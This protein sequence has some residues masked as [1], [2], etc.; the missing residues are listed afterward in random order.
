LRAIV[1]WSR[2][3]AFRHQCAADAAEVD[4]VVL[5][6]AAVLDRDDRV[7]HRR[8]DLVVGHER[9]RF[10]AAKHRED[11][12]AARVVDVAVHLL[13]ELAPRIERARVHLARDR[14]DQPEAERDR[15]E[16]EQGGDEREEPELAD[17]PAL[18]RRSR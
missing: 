13:V 2:S 15:P 6:V 10:R 4:A 5:P 14:A 9:P 16:Q 1:F 17:P 3:S 12:L 7:P 18:P 8:R 11:P